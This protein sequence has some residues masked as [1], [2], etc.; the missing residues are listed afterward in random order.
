MEHWKEH[1]LNSTYE[2]SDLGRLRNKDTGRILKTEV[3]NSG[4]ERVTLPKVPRG[5]D[6]L[7]HRI[8]AIAF[9]EGYQEGLQVDHIDGQKLN[10]KASNLRWV[11]VSQNIRYNIDR[12]TFNSHTAREALLSLQK[13]S[14][15]QYDRFTGDFIRE[16]ES[17]NQASKTV[18]ITATAIHKALKRDSKSTKLYRW[19]WSNPN[20]EHTQRACRIK[21]V[22][23]EGTPHIFPSV[24]K[25]SDFIGVDNSTLHNQ[26]KKGDTI[27]YRGYDITKI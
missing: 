6:E 3:I 16:Y 1:H 7:V 10:N 19:E 8:V 17:L 18:G 21:V 15:K 14:V 22:D 23:F 27:S 4:Y 26:L 5:G 24:R 25:A 2:V 9:C 11:S 12:G 13:K 20:S